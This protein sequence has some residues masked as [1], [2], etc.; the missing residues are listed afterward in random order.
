MHRLVGR[1]ELLETDRLL[2]SLERVLELCQR[3]IAA[4]AERL[5]QRSVHRQD[6]RLAFAQDVGAGGEIEKYDLG[7]DLRVDG[8]EQLAGR[9]DL[10]EFEEAVGE[11]LAAN[12]RVGN[13]ISEHLGER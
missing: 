4:V 7:L 1:E 10:I 3:D 13:E 2:G 11:S 12:L 9:R 8:A 5:E 6:H